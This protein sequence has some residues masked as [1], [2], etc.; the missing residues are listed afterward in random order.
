MLRDSQRKLNHGRPTKTAS[1]SKIKEWMLKNF[2]EKWW[3]PIKNDCDP[4]PQMAGVKPCW[5]CKRWDGW[6]KDYRKGIVK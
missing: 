1:D 4:C 2:K 3:T 5:N 6:I